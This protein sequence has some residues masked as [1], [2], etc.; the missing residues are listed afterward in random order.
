M[1]CLISLPLVSYLVIRPMAT[2]AA[3]DDNG[4]PA[5]NRAKLPAHTEAI[6]EEP[7]DNRV[8]HIHKLIYLDLCLY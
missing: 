6:E 5:S 7:R 1:A 4:T 3:A 8:N 2:P